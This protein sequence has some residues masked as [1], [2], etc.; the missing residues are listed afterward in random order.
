[1]DLL[2]DDKTKS[3]D[4]Y[5]KIRLYIVGYE[6]NTRIYSSSIESRLIPLYIDV[7]SL[8]FSCV[9]NTYL[10]FINQLSLYACVNCLYYYNNSIHIPICDF[11]RYVNK[12]MTNNDAFV[13]INYIGDVISSWRDS[14][15]RYRQ[16]LYI[17]DKSH[18]FD[19]PDYRKRKYIRRLMMFACVD[20]VKDVIIIII[21]LL[22]SL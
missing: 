17:L 3:Y 15:S 11:I 9:C 20:L 16:H 13:H 21:H 4:D 2:T 8:C 19:H 22:L 14:K 10:R 18:D 7:C 1:M 6:D 12:K 5:T